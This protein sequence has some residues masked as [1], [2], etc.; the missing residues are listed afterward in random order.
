M[1]LKS[2]A[3]KLSKAA[4]I[5]YQS[6]L[7]QIRDAGSEPAD[8]KRSYGWSLSR[9]DVLAIEP[10]S[11][12]EWAEVSAGARYVNVE[13]CEECGV[14]YFRSTDKKGMPVAGSDSYC[15]SCLEEHG[16]F[17]CGKCGQDVLGDPGIAVCDACWEY[18]M[19]KD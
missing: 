17:P 5:S 12:P 6:A 3:R 15:P 2:R 7:Q 19:D 10:D 9:A 8:L 11:D 1:S 14:G 16:H 4:G 18:M 13:H